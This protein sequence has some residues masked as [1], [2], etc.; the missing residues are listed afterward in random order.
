MS[1]NDWSRFIDWNLQSRQ[2]FSVQPQLK[3]QAK[4]R[5]HNLL[6]HQLSDE[7]L[8][9]TRLFTRVRLI[10]INP[11]PTTRTMISSS[12]AKTV[13]YHYQSVMSARDP[14]TAWCELMR[15]SFFMDAST[16]PVC[17]SL[18]SALIHYCNTCLE[19][20]N[21]SVLI[22]GEIV[23][24]CWNFEIHILFLSYVIKM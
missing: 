9:S 6:L 18:M 12:L 2:S 1:A 8:M 11:M 10:Q 17:G 19:T 4:H 22:F 3:W 21:C 13:I 20:F 15:D 24:S 14:H 16:R 7:L 23:S 5:F